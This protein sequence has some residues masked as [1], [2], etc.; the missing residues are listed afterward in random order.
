MIKK[1][2][3]I[4]LLLCAA[5]LMCIFGFY[6]NSGDTDKEYVI[7]SYSSLSGNQSLIYSITDGKHLILIDGGWSIDANAIYHYI[8]SQGGV[9]DA[10]ILTHPHPDHIGAF[11]EV[12]QM[13]DID[14][15]Q[16]Y[17]TPVD[18]EFYKAN[19]HPW[20][21]F[22]VYENFLEQMTN[23]KKLAYVSEGDE[24]DLDGIRMKVLYAYSDDLIEKYESKDPCN[25]GGIVFK[26]SGRT[27]SMLFLADVGARMSPYIIENHAEDLKCDYV[28]MGHH[29]NGGSSEELLSLVSP[30]VAFFDCTE[31]IM[32]NESLNAGAKRRFME[33]LGAEIFYY[34]DAPHSIVLH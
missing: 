7:T 4:L 18:Y 34:K 14:I 31:D 11:N 16:I 30:R 5:V 17:A 1:I 27:E 6:S 19:A 26:L 22:D 20:D 3:F 10:W 9:V 24:Y 21:E 2:L 12:C 13:P 29:G 33:E 28:Q 25:D 32:Q 8:L 23:N 15:K